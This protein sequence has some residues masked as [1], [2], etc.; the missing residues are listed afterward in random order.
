MAV[1][2]NVKLI[3]DDAVRIL[4]VLG[5]NVCG[6]YVIGRAGPGIDDAAPVDIASALESR[7][8]L[9][10]LLRNL[11]DDGGLLAIAGAE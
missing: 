11:E 8:L 9:H 1:R 5:R 3:E 10:H 4:A 7:L 2:L 6:Q